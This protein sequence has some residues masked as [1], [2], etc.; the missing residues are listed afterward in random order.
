MKTEVGGEGK[1][2]ISAQSLISLLSY[3]VIIK[4]NFT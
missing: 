2:A 4:Q 3:I 1:T